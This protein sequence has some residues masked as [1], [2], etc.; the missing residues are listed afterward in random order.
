MNEMPMLE[1]RQT[2][3]NWS[4]GETLGLND[5]ADRRSLLD[6]GLFDASWYGQTYPDL[7][8]QDA[9]SHFCQHGWK[10]GRRP[11]PYFA[12]D[13]YLREN[14]DVQRGG[15]NP[16]LH[17]IHFGEAGGR[18]PAPFFDLVWYRT[19][20]TAE[21]GE[22]LLRHF[23]DRRLAGTVS[24]LPEFDAA[25]YLENYPDIA[26]AG[27][28]PFEHYLFW[29]YKEGRNPSAKFDTRYYQRRYLDGLPDENPLLHYRQMRNFL[30]VHPMPS[31]SETGV[32]ADVRAFGRPGPAFEEF[33][34]LPRHATRRAKL[35][36][37]YLP[38]FHA[39]PEN[40]AWWGTGF[41]EWTAIARGMPRFAGHYQPRT[42]RDLGHYTLEDS[43]TL[44]RQIEMAR[45]AGL[46][47]F[48]H[49]FYWFNGRRLLERPI[50]AMLADASLDFPF[51]L[52]WA[53]ENWTRRWDG[54]DD[55]VLI[56]Q[57]WRPEDEPDLV[58]CFAR[59]FRDPRYIRLQGRPLLMVYRPALIPD[60][61]ATIARWRRLFR[62]RHGE[63]PVLVMSQSFN[64]TD[65]R[66]FGF[67]AAAEFPPHK[68]VGGLPL[69]NNNLAY[70]DPEASAQI[71]AYD[72]L[73]TASLAEPIAD[74][75]QIK[76]IV[77]SWDN[78]ARRQ[79]AGL[80][81]HG[82][83]P[84]KYGAW[85]AALVARAEANPVFGEPL[86]CV[87]AW[88]EWAEGAYLEPD[89]HFG[90]AYLNATARAV[91]G[92]VPSCTGLLLVG[93]DA[94][95]A[96]AQML[97]LHLAR[98]LVQKRGVQLEILLLGD[99]VLRAQYAAI[100]PTIL[101]G[102][103]AIEPFLAGCVARGI[104][105]AIVNSA[106]SASIVPALH[107]AMIA[108]VLLVHELPRMIE[109]HGL[110]AALAA[111]LPLAEKTI[112]AA[113]AVQD[114][115]AS[116]APIPPDRAM[117]APQGC[118][119]ANVFSARAR[120]RL[121]NR[122]GLP[123]SQFVVLGAG[124]A[125]LRKGFDLFLQTW[126]AVRRRD[127]QIMFCWIGDLDPML[128][129]HLA[130]EIAAA[131]ATGTFLLPGRQDDVADWYSAADAFAL[132]SREDPFPSVVL[133]AM[134]AGLPS[135]AFLGS[136]GIPDMLARLEVGQSVPMADTETMA[137]QLLATL[138]N[139]SLVAD[140]P[141]IAAIARRNF[142]FDTYVET[143][144]ATALPKLARISIIVPSYNYARYLPAR[145]G[146]I[147]RQTYPVTEVLLL[148]DASSD[149]SVIVAT[150]VAA[151]H[152]RDLRIVANSRNSGSVFRQWR[153]G[154][155][156]A[157]GDYVWIAEADD[158][159]DPNLLATL[160]SQ[161]NAA[162]DID[163]VCCD[164]RSIDADGKIIWPSYQN[165]YATS[166]PE[167]ARDSIFPARDFARRCLAERNLILNAS[168]VLWR[169]PA[170]RAALDR[171]WDTL[172]DL[173][174]AG[175]WFLYL[176]LLAHSDGHVAWIAQP[177]NIHRRHK[178]SVTGAL[179]THRHLDEIARV[180]TTARTLLALDAPS[181]ER[182]AAYLRSVADGLVEGG[183]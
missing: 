55:A 141:R 35:L 137:R 56:A 47:G 21:A 43:E 103:T 50:E 54:A 70:Y 149:D 161:L 140:R 60:T 117:I 69:Q 83:T 110:Q 176:N 79:G 181:I 169:K 49:Y 158:D 166:A 95:P 114:G 163:L 155:E 72:D 66:D 134:S 130:G 67:D 9:L 33:R 160:A 18:A 88:N 159:A 27:I 44:R 156:L 26:A 148:D 179:A 172:R 119:R 76:T 125:D 136:G 127:K 101:L 48:V 25:F 171:S 146:S 96:G 20:H 2:D 131:V 28:D 93:H 39:I 80:V 51:C 180:Q 34:P 15:L 61:K 59:H 113:P 112:F 165:Y 19:V 138:R 106:A 99:G 71:Y 86:L 62:D 90:G 100:A 63:D 38:Q 46:F 52:M 14:Q 91:T 65:P 167:L 85:L 32:F 105:H 23:L 84:A 8:D 57:D 123:A 30:K 41:T 144:L 42:P 94:F 145:L 10:E 154:A 124:Y 29:G 182:Q 1:L 139:P 6:S 98:T 170:L 12:T 143:L 104:G 4:R 77:P 126:R 11:N 133:E 152:Q 22:T 82:S 115:T 24:P 7:A 121:R 118:Y 73:A 174:M 162:P 45:G 173:R 151:T 153:R 108:S 36:A 102:S 68:L 147:F 58:D 78:D 135:L 111:A 53:N 177:L 97:L 183:A 13:W 109:S 74:F 5:A 175:D 132:T 157:R 31:A 37:Y 81:V 129:S 92:A 168:A 17:Y 120:Q 40:D 116:L 128:R 142:D 107:R 64:A 150:S 89:V 164:S 87:N 75:P 122:L 16:L 3:E 178:A